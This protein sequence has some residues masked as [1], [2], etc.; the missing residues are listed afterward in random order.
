MS[1]SFRYSVHSVHVIQEEEDDKTETSGTEPKS[2]GVLQRY[3]NEMVKCKYYA[4]SVIQV[5]ES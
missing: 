1:R 3:N 4:F 5:A 2:V